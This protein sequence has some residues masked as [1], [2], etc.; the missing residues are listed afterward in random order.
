MFDDQ[1]PAE[2]ALTPQKLRDIMPVLTV[3][4]ARR[5]HLPWLP[6]QRI[7]TL[8]R[9]G[10]FPKGVV[11]HLGR[12]VFFKEAA[13]IDFIRSGDAGQRPGLFTTRIVLDWRSD[14]AAIGHLVA[15]AKQNSG[16]PVLRC[17]DIGD[18][19]RLLRRVKGWFS[20]GGVL[21]GKGPVIMARTSKL[22]ETQGVD[23]A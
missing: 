1:L 5:D 15:G 3:A 4:E 9:R 23:H 6:M 2:S 22:R 21:H 11:V 18:D 19:N 20:K 8:V 12:R 7:Y 13:L 10:I 16:L 14:K 17:E